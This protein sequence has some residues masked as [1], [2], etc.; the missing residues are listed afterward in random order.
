MTREWDKAFMTKLYEELE[1]YTLDGELCEDANTQLWYVKSVFPLST[2]G[3]YS[4]MAQGL[5]F[6]LTDDAVSLEI[7]FD[8]TNDVKPECMDEM[9]KTVNE[10][11]Y[12]SPAGA[13]GVRERL[14]KLYMRNCWVIDSKKEIEEQVKDAVF[15]Y[16]AQVRCLQG[17]YIGLK[18]VWTGELT[19]EEAVE[20]ELLR[21]SPVG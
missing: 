8:I 6:P 1:D 9:K 5:A 14:G 11:N 10:L 7:I 20:Q 12:I 19:F 16:D 4:V 13:F 15:A 2:D 17:G 21:K 3:K 18:K